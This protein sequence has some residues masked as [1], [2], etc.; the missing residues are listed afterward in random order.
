MTSVELAKLIG[1][2]QSTVSRALNDS[3]LISKEI[4][5]KIKAE[6]EKHGYV[7]NN[8]ARSL[9]TKK[10]G[11]IGILF[12]V[13]FESLGKNLMFAH[14][15][16]YLQ[17]ELIKN[18][19][20][21]L[22]VY[23][24]GKSPKNVFENILKNHKVDG[25]ISLRPT[26]KEK[27][28][29]LL[30]SLNYPF[31]SLFLSPESEV[32]PNFFGMDETEL[33]TCAGDYFSKSEAKAKIAML[34][35]STESSESSRDRL[36]GFSD[37]LAKNNRILDSFFECGFNMSDAY[38][39]VKENCNFFRE[40]KVSLFVYNDMLAV[41]AIQALLELNVRIPEDTEIISID[42]IPLASW[43]HPRLSTVHIPVKDM[44][45]DGCTRLIEMING[46]TF[47]PTTNIYKPY[48]V[49]TQTTKRGKQN[50]KHCNDYV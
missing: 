24:Y 48:L 22:M 50:E 27:E 6:A 36:K 17:Q 13:H 10:T 47:P 35:L 8:Q 46:G 20:D 15:Y 32:V 9:K 43:V 40:N 31:V 42:D 5:E 16:D 21:V 3:P 44:V 18:G 26:L 1:V 45:F 19:Y 7:V 39:V 37:S 23:D 11:T 4:R 14:I 12:P 34:S 30:S 49:F 41:G 29:N 25:I 2:S 38:D 33:G 28:L